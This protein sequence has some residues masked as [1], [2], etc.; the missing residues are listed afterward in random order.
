MAQFVG[1][2]TRYRY[3][4]LKNLPPF[5]QVQFAFKRMWYAFRM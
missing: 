3:L 2:E 4:I 5:L 1:G